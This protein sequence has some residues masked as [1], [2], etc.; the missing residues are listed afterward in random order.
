MEGDW[1]DLFDMKD[2][3]KRNGLEKER[4]LLLISER[5]RIQFGD[6]LKGKGEEEEEMN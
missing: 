6:D 3:L 2:Y 1:T 5:G 4:E